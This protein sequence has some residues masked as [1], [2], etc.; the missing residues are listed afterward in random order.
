ML[1]SLVPDSSR[2]FKFEHPVE[3][4][5]I[6]DCI[7]PGIGRD[8][9]PPI[10]DARDSILPQAHLI[11]GSLPRRVGFLGKQRADDRSRFGNADP[12]IGNVAKFSNDEYQ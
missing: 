7:H 2:Q 5:V 9:A 12:L 8:G 3:S 4:G 1:G 6:D 11:C 10:S